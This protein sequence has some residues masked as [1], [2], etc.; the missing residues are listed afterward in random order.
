MIT[1]I[2][3]RKLAEQEVA[4]ARDKALEASRAK[5]EFLARLSHELRTPLNPVLLLASEAANNPALPD[6]VRADFETIAQNVTL[7]ARLI[8]DLLDLT[9]ITRGKVA[10]D[11][12]PVQ[13]HSVLHDALAMMRQDIGAKQLRITLRL[14]AEQHVVLGDDMR[15]KQVFLERHQE[16]RKV[17]PARG[18]TDDHH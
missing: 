16:R 4:A 10:L 12:R 6:E 11:F 14:K 18:R 13:I 8:D 7:E 9:A 17:Y 2:T 15:L 3:E 5:D 1:D